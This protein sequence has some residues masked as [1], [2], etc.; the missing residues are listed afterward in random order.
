MIDF[1]RPIGFSPAAAGVWSSNSPSY[2]EF[3]SLSLGA[4]NFAMANPAMRLIS[5]GYGTGAGRSYSLLDPGYRFGSFGLSAP[6]LGMLNYE[7][8]IPDFTAPVLAMWRM[9]Y[10]APAAMPAGPAQ[11]AAP[12]PP[13]PAS[14]PDGAGKKGDEARGEGATDAAAAGKGKRKGKG[15]PAAPTAKIAAEFQQ[16]LGKMK[17]AGGMDKMDPKDARRLQQLAKKYPSLIPKGKPEDDTKKPDAVPEAGPH[18]TDADSPPAASDPAAVKAR[19]LARL[20]E[21]EQKA[22][23][24]KESP[25]E[26]AELQRLQR[27]PDLR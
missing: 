11:A 8:R 27:D 19:K 7:G 12:Q 13:P 16:L 2:N 4:S 20:R 9:L 3:S 1:S 23:D 24:R 5:E 21:L 22:Y 14:T 25:A 17:A 6:M 18:K 26:A 10:P 15:R